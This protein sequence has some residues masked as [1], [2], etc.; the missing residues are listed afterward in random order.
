[1]TTPRTTPAPSWRRVLAGVLDG[2]LVCG[3]AWGLRRKP[4]TGI[5][6]W[7][8]WLWLITTAAQLVREQLGSPGQRLLELAAVDKRTGSRLE[9]WR[10]LVGIGADAAGRAVRHRLMPPPE[11]ERERERFLEELAGIRKR[12]PDDAAAGEAEQRAL[13]ERHPRRNL[14][15][16]M[17]PSLAIGLATDRL[18]RR[19]APT[20][21]ILVRRGR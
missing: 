20:T 6:R 7:E 4:R 18:R 17:L 21:E 15:A 14:W 2:A 13:F 3:V 8:E 5:G 12:H 16:T 19:L 1:M 10:S 9:L 11:W